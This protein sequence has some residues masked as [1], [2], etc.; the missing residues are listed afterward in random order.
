MAVPSLGPVIRELFAAGLAASSQRTYRSGERKYV[1]FCQV[2]KLTPFPATE[3]VLTAFVA[4]LHTQGL[5]V[6]TVKSYLAAMRHTQIAIGLGDPQIGSMPQLEY[7]LKGLKRR[8]A[9]RQGRPRLPITPTVLRQLKEVWARMPDRHNAAMLWAASTLCFF[10]FLR[11]GEAVSPT[12]GYDPQVHLSFGDARV[13]NRS[14][15][16]WMEV[17]IK[18]SKTDP[19]RRGVTIYI[20]VTG[21]DLCPV[22]ALLGYMVVRGNHDG[23]MVCS[24][25]G[26]I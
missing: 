13:N 26:T 16:E 20:G 7:V 19:F 1:T 22:A 5:A 2:Y 4:A 25:M 24:R 18:E 8:S 9:G 21:G 17:R 15:P 10:G 11:T 3:P 12:I 6:G 14:S 23:P